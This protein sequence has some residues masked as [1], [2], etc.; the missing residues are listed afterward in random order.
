MTTLSG[1]TAGIKL[2]GVSKH[3]LSAR[4][5]VST[6][7]AL[8]V[9]SLHVAAGAFVCLV[10][11][12]GCGKSTI[13]NLIAGLEQP[14]TGNIFLDGRPISGPGPDR[15]MVFQ[16]PLLFPWLDVIENVTF[17][18]NIV[19][20]APGEYIPIAQRL[21]E[22]VGLKGFERHKSYELSGGMKQRVA[23]ARAWIGNP[24]VLL[25][26]EPFAALD[27]Q[28]R[29]LMQEQLVALWES[30]KHTVVFVTHDV[31]EALLLADRVIVMTARPGRIRM[32]LQVD[33]PRPRSYQTLFRDPKYSKLK[34]EVFRLVR[35]ETMKSMQQ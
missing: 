27:A 18:P 10:G 4:N 26:D 31:D 20:R 3:F 28:T 15:G 24:K 25:M 7:V 34:S 35:E 6:T 9:L 17:G 2:E 32:D 11:P 12:S 23:L 5:E 13:L 14:S 21:V 1:P 22:T 33:L 16:E 19:G 8:E 30:N 29:L